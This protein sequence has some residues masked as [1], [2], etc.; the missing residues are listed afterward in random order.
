[1][2]WILLND[3]ITLQRYYTCHIIAQILLKLTLNTNQCSIQRL[4]TSQYSRNTAKVGIKHQSMLNTKIMYIPKISC[5]V[6][7]SPLTFN[8]I[9]YQIMSVNLSFLVWSTHS[10]YQSL[11]GCFIYDLWHELIYNHWLVDLYMTSDMN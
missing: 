11:I 5:F 8:N 1:M 6:W 10:A 3:L 7:Q 4:Y 9:L 2:F